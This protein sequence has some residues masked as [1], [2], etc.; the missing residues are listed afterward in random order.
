MYGKG[1]SVIEDKS[2]LGQA[3]G[4]DRLTMQKNFIMRSCF[5]M[6]L[7]EKSMVLRQRLHAG[8]PIRNYLTSENVIKT[9]D[10]AVQLFKLI[11]QTVTGNETLTKKDFRI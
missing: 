10:P 4:Q 11:K 2:N 1:A 9:I 7:K 5:K 8:L 6:L 3:E